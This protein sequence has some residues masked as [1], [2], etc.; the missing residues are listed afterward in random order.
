MHLPPGLAAQGGGGT[1][2][3]DQFSITSSIHQQH[4]Q[5]RTPARVSPGLLRETLKHYGFLQESELH[6][7]TGY[8]YIWEERPV[9]A[10]RTQTQVFIQFHKLRVIIL[11][12]KN[13]RYANETSS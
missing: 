3:L 2:S 12:H 8:I 13:N 1:Q 11:F 6:P 10:A 9:H 7:Q 5:P 4:P